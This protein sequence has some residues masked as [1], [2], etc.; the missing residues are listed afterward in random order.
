MSIRYQISSPSSSSSLA[1][2]PRFSRSMLWLAL[3]AATA[4][5]VAGTS[6]SSVALQRRKVQVP[7]QDRKSGEV[8]AGVVHK[9]AYFGKVHIGT[10]SQSFTVVFDTGSGNL[11][12]PA[13]DCQS[14]ACRAH[15]TFT[16]NQSSSV[17]EVS[18]TGAPRQA[19]DS[20]PEDEVTI[21]FGT[22]EVWGRCAQDN[23]CLGSVC[24]KG[25][26][27]LAT[28]ESSSPFNAFKFDGV[29]GLGLRSMSQGD[30]FN[31]MDQFK[32]D[33]VLDQALFSVFMSDSDDELS[34]ISFGRVKNEHLMS[35][36]F[37]VDVARDSGYWE[38]QVNDITV[39]DV[40]QQL[41]SGCYAAVDTGT[42]ELAGPTEIITKL[43]E[44][45]GVRTDCSNFDS[46]PRLGFQIGGHVLNLEPRD[47]VDRSAADH[48]EVALMPLDVP[49][50]QGPLF[51]LGIPFLQKFYTAYD[52]SKKQVGFGVAHHVGQ[53]AS[54]AKALLVEVGTA[55]TRRASAPSRVKSF[56]QRFLRWVPE[57]DQ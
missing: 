39:N 40:P 5:L 55:V 47:Y 28:Y 21:T 24:T 31:L 44:T 33:Q 35:D 46:L 14:D 43:A 37:W 26:F 25:S 51:I 50:P 8:V 41:C 36:M 18:C 2:A 4:P 16:E 20:P 34:E 32:Q 42:S 29:L 13:S 57:V 30:Q 9:T 7:K 3:A 6:A 17:Q 52:A 1:A 10:P 54:S 19:G 53:D 56:L 49:P 12:V 27:V 38:V 48:C 15:A 23:I 45:L 11:L 22:G